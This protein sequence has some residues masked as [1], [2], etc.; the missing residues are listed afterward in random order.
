M[1]AGV[2]HASMDL[3]KFKDI[4]VRKG[5]DI[6]RDIMDG[7]EDH[8]VSESKF[9]AYIDQQSAVDEHAG[10]VL[11]LL[12]DCII[13]INKDEIQKLTLNM[14]NTLLGYLEGLEGSDSK[15]YNVLSAGIPDTMTFGDCDKKSNLLIAILMYCQVPMLLDYLEGFVCENILLFENSIDKTVG[16]FVLTDDIVFSGTEMSNDM[17][18]TILHFGPRLEKIR[19]CTCLMAITTKGE[20]KVRAVSAHDMYFD[21]D[22]VDS[23]AQMSEL[24]DDEKM[25]RLQKLLVPAIKVE[26]RFMFQK[27]GIP[28][29]MRQLYDKIDESPMYSVFRDDD[30]NEHTQ[31]RSTV[32]RFIGGEPAERPLLYSDLKLAT[33][34][35]TFPE[36]FHRPMILHPFGESLLKNCSAAEEKDALEVFN[37]NFCPKPYYKSNWFTEKVEKGQ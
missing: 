36:F 25:E 34:L 21:Q 1:N 29:L 5:D 32:R 17:Y 18:H 30:S 26:F 31:M 15:F 6:L 19:I 8:G 14:G 7:I 3:V 16:T 27:L 23:I 37:G 24:T 12:K 13:H 28:S 2:Q 20:Q 22:D 11:R 9:N 4:V 10:L 33:A 35:T